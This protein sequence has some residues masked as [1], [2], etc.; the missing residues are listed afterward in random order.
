MLDPNSNQNGNSRPTTAT[1]RLDEPLLCQG[2]RGEPARFAAASEIRL[3]P[4]PTHST[5]NRGQPSIDRWF[6]DHGTDRKAGARRVSGTH[7]GGSVQKGPWTE[8]NNDGRRMARGEE[9]VAWPVIFP[10]HVLSPSSKPSSEP[11]RIVVIAS[12]YPD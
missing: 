2:H 4:I 7:R 11:I 10:H 1:R 3:R 9:G 5:S 6:A 8:G 12:L